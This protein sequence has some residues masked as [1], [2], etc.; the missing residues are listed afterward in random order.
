MD[1]D[2]DTLVILDGC[3]YD[4]FEK[5]NS[6][7]GELRKVTSGGSS[8]NEFMKYNFSDICAF[9]TIYISA[10]PFLSRLDL[11]ANFYQ[12]VHLWRDQWDEELKT[13]TPEAVVE[14]TLDTYSRHPDKRLIVHFMQPHYPFIGENGRDISQQGIVDDSDDTLRIWDQLRHRELDRQT[15]LKAYE[16]NLELVLPHVQRLID[17]LNGR[18]VVTA[19]HGNCFGSHGVYGHPPNI[20]VD[21]LVGVPWLVVPGQDQREITKGDPNRYSDDS[22]EA[23]V[24][25]RLSNLGYLE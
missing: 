12:S 17:E 16:E 7:N 5:L 19:D 3:R 6:L 18:T 10:N 25:D 11:D 1:Q 23:A 22:P 20:F 15:A 8:S 13:V 2:W 14:A 4:T 24:A 21:E 9:D